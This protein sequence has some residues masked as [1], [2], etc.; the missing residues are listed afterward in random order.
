MDWQGCRNTVTLLRVTTLC[1]F[2][3]E[4]SGAAMRLVSGVQKMESRGDRVPNGPILGRLYAEPGRLHPESVARA[5]ARALPVSRRASDFAPPRL[6]TSIFPG[7]SRVVRVL[8][9]PLKNPGFPRVFRILDQ[10]LWLSCL[11]MHVHA[12]RCC[13]VL[14]ATLAPGESRE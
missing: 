4:N 9:S 11:S 13:V 6:E 3:F 14:C 8:S 5:L 10:S 7:I 12:C 2:A 1:T